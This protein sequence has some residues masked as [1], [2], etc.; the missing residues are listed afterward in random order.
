MIKEAI[1]KVA[2]KVKS[3]AD[4]F[5]SSAGDEFDSA[6]I[7]SVVLSNEELPPPEQEELLTKAVY[8]LWCED[9]KNF[10]VWWDASDLARSYYE[11]REKPKRASHKTNAMMNLIFSD[12]ETIKPDI[13]GALVRPTLY[14]TEKEN[15]QAAEMLNL[16]SRNVWRDSN[17]HKE[18]CSEIIHDVLMDGVAT[19]KTIFDGSRR[20]GRGDVRAMHIDSRRVTFKK[21]SQIH[22]SPYILDTVIGS[23]GEARSM[24]RN[25]AKKIKG[26]M[27]VDDANKNKSDGPPQSELNASKGFVNLNVPVPDYGEAAGTGVQKISDQSNPMSQPFNDAKSVAR[28]ECWFWDKTLGEDGNPV[29]PEGR[30]VTVGVGTD[31]EKDGTGKLPELVVLADRP[32][33]YVNLARK[34]GIFPIFQAQCHKVK[35]E[36]GLSEVFHRI[37]PQVLIND[38][39]N[40]THDNWKLTNSGPTLGLARAG[41]T[42]KTWKPSPD[43]FIELSG[44]IEDATK[45]VH[46]MQPIPIGHVSLPFLQ[47]YT[48]LFERTG[49]AAD[50]L[51]GRKPE[52][53]T[54]GYAITALQNRAKGRFSTIGR[55]INKTFV[56]LFYGIACCVQDFDQPYDQNYDQKPITLI[57]DEADPNKIDEKYVQYDPRATKEVDFRSEVTRQMS[58]EEAATFLSEAANLD[59]NGIPG[60][61]ELMLSY[62][63]DPSLK[64]RYQELIATAKAEA[65]AAAEAQAKMESDKQRRV[66]VG[67]ITEKVVEAKL[68]AGKPQGSTSNNTGKKNVQSRK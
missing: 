19:F 34:K 46:R 18:E 28:I 22:E 9:K 30:I 13:E 32:N 7:V 25:K 68:Q 20:G 40:T 6:K 59:K 29:Y 48:S 44:D 8:A 53:V 42:T 14:P 66:Q 2:G 21:G 52:G 4:S 61:G 41:V 15:R 27:I 5:K 45:V 10:Q 36:W 63:D 11:G 65:Q 64:Y 35:K 37:D 26:G 49:G 24:F 43:H 58:V 16:R 67:K 56:E 17:M 47:A 33:P 1:S 50:A 3:W 23:V 39:I 51:A 54:A 57:N 55:N 31:S 60:M 38:V 12:I 62:A